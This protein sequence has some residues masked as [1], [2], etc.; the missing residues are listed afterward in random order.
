MTPSRS[1]APAIAAGP[2]QPDIL[3]EDMSASD[4]VFVLE[5]LHF[6]RNTLAALRLDRE[7]RDYLVAALRRTHGPAC[8]QEAAGAPNGGHGCRAYGRRQVTK[9][10]GGNSTGAARLAH[11]R[12]VSTYHVPGTVDR[13]AD[14]RFPMQQ[15][16]LGIPGP[17]R[18]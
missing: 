9:P 6:G 5:N 2:A 16:T 13:C 10:S 11:R 7:V 17:G 14:E 12:P 18:S 4:I 1:A 8:A 3:D 15:G